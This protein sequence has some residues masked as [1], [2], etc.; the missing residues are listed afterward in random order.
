M[1][2]RRSTAVFIVSRDWDGGDL[3]FWKFWKWTGREGERVCVRERERGREKDKVK[4][5][6]QQ[7]RLVIYQPLFS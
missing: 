7:L 6:K 2:E 4:R 3:S 1:V 5:K